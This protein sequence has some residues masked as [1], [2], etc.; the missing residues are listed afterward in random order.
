M[1]A[2]DHRGGLIRHLAGSGIEVGPGHNPLVKSNTWLAVRYVDRWEPNRNAE[3]FP[4]LDGATFPMPDLVLDLDRDGLKPVAGESEDFIVASHV[5]EHL[6]NPLRAISEFHRVLRPGGTLLILLPDRRRTFD[7]DRPPTGLDHVVAEFEAGV[8]EVD[9]E[10]IIEF[11]TNT[12]GADEELEAMATDPEQRTTVLERHRS[13]SIHVHCW[14]IEE[15]VQILR[16]SIE[17]M[18]NRW[19][20]VDGL[21]TDEQGPD[22]IE[23]GLV[24]R[25]SSTGISP[26]QLGQLFAESFEQWI[27]ATEH[28]LAQRRAVEE[29]ISQ[30]KAAVQYLQARLEP[31]EAAAAQLEPAQ[32]ALGALDRDMQTLL[33][34]KTFRYTT[35][36]RHLYG[37]VRRVL[38]R[39]P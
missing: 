13:R 19:Q 12:G 36:L 26:A 23:F 22:A 24:L 31:A 8:T 33:A 1:A 34:T 14:T 4:E 35:R 15:F 39:S 25:R 11:L 37:R 21:S 29:H 9:D 20:F 30:L 18:G 28:A 6:A 7:K 10:H 38:T 27:A 2:F 32:R 17:E 5:L 3:L 16:Y